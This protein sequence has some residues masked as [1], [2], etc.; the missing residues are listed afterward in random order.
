MKEQ[1]IDI[2][3]PNLGQPMEL[4][5]APAEIAPEEPAEEAAPE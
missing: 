2:T 4:T 1:G 5:P 3:N